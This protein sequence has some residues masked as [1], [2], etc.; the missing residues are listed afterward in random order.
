MLVLDSALAGQMLMASSYHGTVLEALKQENDP[1]SHLPCVVGLQERRPI[2][3]RR[4]RGSSTHSTR[5]PRLAVTR[6]SRAARLR[7]RTVPGSSSWAAPQCQRFVPGSSQSRPLLGGLARDALRAHSRQPHSRRQ[8]PHSSSSSSQAGSRQ[9][10][11]ALG[12]LWAAMGSQTLLATRA[13]LSNSGATREKQGQPTPA[14]TVPTHN[15]PGIL[16]T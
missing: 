14:F 1:L 7:Q 16:C 5:L 6:G 8:A 15:V 10:T 2:S 12:S 11:G 4:W 9:V 13:S 3:R